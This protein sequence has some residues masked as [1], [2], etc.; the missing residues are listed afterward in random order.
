[1]LSDPGAGG[2]IPAHR[3]QQVLDDADAVAEQRQL[4]PKEYQLVSKPG[5]LSAGHV[6]IQCLCHNGSSLQHVRT[7]LFHKLFLRTD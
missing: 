2:G 5:D 3:A 4:L 7:L 6:S 1:M